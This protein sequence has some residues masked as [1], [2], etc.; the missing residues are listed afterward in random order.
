MSCLCR[1]S[2]SWRYE[3]AA[4]VAVWCEVGTRCFAS[5]NGCWWHVAH[6]TSARDAMIDE[7]ILGLLG[8]SSLGAISPTE[9]N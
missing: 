7:R 3:G 1:L 5:V 8:N 2:S 6:G 9:E 4:A